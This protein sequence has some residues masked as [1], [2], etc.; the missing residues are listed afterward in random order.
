M[1]ESE[2]F[3]IK[4]IFN[5]LLEVI[6]GKFL[7]CFD[8]TIH[9]IAYN[10]LQFTLRYQVKKFKVIRNKK[11]ENHAVSNTITYLVSSPLPITAK[12]IEK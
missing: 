2:R 5:L 10:M 1:T 4:K 8:S 7:D 9:E 11:K 12:S 3:D 6:V